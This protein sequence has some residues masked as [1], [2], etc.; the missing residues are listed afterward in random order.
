MINPIISISKCWESLPNNLGEISTFVNYNRLTNEILS[1]SYHYSH[2][3][4]CNTNHTL[5]FSNYNDLMCVIE[6]IDA[7]IN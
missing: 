4:G 2:T 1:V 3:F 5:R 7:Y 6:Q